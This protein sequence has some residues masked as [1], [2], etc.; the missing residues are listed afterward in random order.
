[1]L[2]E[3]ESAITKFKKKYFMLIVIIGT[4]SLLIGLAVGSIIL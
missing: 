4:V 3:N 1:M 2:N